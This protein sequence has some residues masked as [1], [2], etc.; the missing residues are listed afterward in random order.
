MKMHANADASLAHGKALCECQLHSHCV[1][2]GAD[3][4][5]MN[6]YF[7]KKKLGNGAS[8]L[9]SKYS[10]DWGEGE[11]EGITYEMRFQVVPPY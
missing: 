11:R 4:F 1:E 9:I 8:L 2:I 10:A 7:F 6:Q 3:T 5:C